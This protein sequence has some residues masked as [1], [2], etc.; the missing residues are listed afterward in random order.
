MKS[1]HY[2]LIAW[3]SL[4]IKERC[5]RTRSICRGWK[6]IPYISPHVRMLVAPLLRLCIHHLG[7]PGHKLV[8]EPALFWL[9]L[10]FYRS[11]RSTPAH[12][13]CFAERNRFSEPFAVSRLYLNHSIEAI[14]AVCS[15]SHMNG[16]HQTYESLRLLRMLRY[17][18]SDDLRRSR[19][20]RLRVNMGICVSCN[21]QGIGFMAG[22]G[23]QLLEAL[24][25]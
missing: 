20:L 3:T 22:E 23:F 21:R 7:S 1:D 8:S 4:Q 13:V 2:L 14:S 18:H 17:A 12:R 16:K 9:F 24:M 10:F 6:D 15:C 19:A 11:L 25:S 5:T